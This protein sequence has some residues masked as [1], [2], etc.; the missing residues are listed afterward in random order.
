[1]IWGNV[2]LP[3][4]LYLFGTVYRISEDSHW[5]DLTWLDLVI[6]CPTVPGITAKFT[7]LSNE[8]QKI[9][10]AQ[11]RASWR[12]WLRRRRRK[13]RRMDGWVD[14]WITHSDISKDNNKNKL[15]I[16]SNLRAACNLPAFT[17]KS[18]HTGKLFCNITKVTNVTKSSAN[19]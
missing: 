3:T 19:I 10:L 16:T 9:E 12:C 18:S 11:K 13:R 14:G 17:L 2:I 4:E 1:M 6:L 8:K 15:H 5:L 7:K